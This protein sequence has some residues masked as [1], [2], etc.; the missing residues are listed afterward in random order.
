[1]TKEQKQTPRWCNW[2]HREFAR[3]V[4]D[5]NVM[6]ARCDAWRAF[7]TS[8][9]MQRLRRVKGHFIW[10][11]RYQMFDHLIAEFDCTERR[12][13]KVI[14]ELVRPEFAGESYT[15]QRKDIYDSRAWAALPL[16]WFAKIDEREVPFIE[17]G[18]RLPWTVSRKD[19]TLRWRWKHGRKLAVM[20]FDNSCLDPRFE[21]KRWVAEDRFPQEATRQ[22]MWDALFAEVTEKC[23]TFLVTIVDKD[24]CE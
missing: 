20:T 19:F 18:L 15:F 12:L 24:G 21:K 23:R 8:D 13:R 9:T 7:L 4:N 1:V 17:F 11:N 3:E 22:Q 2:P 5:L 16:A 10:F 14:S 6:G